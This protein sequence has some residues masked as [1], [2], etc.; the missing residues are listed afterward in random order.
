MAQRFHPARLLLTF[1]I[2][3]RMHTVEGWLEDGEADLLIAASA[4]ALSTLSNGELVEIGSYCGKSTVVLGSV[5]KLVRPTA[6]VYAIDPHTGTVGSIEH[7]YEAGA[8][9]LERFLQNIRAADLTTQ[10]EVVQQLSFEVVWK[11]PIA[12]MFIDG[13]H[14]YLNVSRDFRHFEKWIV[15]GGLIAFHDYKDYTPGVMKFVDELPE[16]GQYEKVA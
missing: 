12:F 10:V 16:L 11:K 4:H 1:P 2:L 9:T 15:P 14:D 6:R 8:E 7:G 5:A 13:L 3:D